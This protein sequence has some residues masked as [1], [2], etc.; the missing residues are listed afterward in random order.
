[1]PTHIR[2]VAIGTRGDV[3]PYVALGLGLQAAG[4]EVSLATTRDFADVVT[5]AGLGLLVSPFDLRQALAATANRRNSRRA[6]SA[7]L[8]DMMANLV[9]LCQGADLVLYSPVTS[10]IMPDILE[11]LRIGGIPA[12]LQ[13]FVHPTANFPPG[14]FPRL[15]LSR[16]TNRLSYRIVERVTLAK[17]PAQGQP[18]ATK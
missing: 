4:Y 10:V 3:Q 13:P 6:R 7:L 15:P 8:N 9:S 17:H 5:A 2:L 1:M 18:L 12:F 14:I 16:W 11:H